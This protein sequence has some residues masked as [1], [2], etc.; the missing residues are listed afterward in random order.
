MKRRSLIRLAAA[1]P[2]LA[3]SAQARIKSQQASGPQYILA[4]GVTSGT[5]YPVGLGMQRMVET[6]LEPRDPFELRAISSAGSFDN[7][8]FLRSDTA[9]M[10][11]SQALYS[12]YAS[13]GNGPWSE[14]GPVKGIRSVTALWLMLN[15]SWPVQDC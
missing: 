13:N 15:I 6:T 8:E 4:T 7:I 2:L 3:G 9:Q 1:A 11:F 10:G 5:Y 14:I 12:G